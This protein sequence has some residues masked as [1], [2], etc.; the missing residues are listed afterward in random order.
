[1]KWSVCLTAAMLLVAPLPSFAQQRFALIVS[2]AAGGPEY[3]TQY[4]KWSAALSKTLTESL[5]FD[6]ALVTVLSDT[7]RTL[8]P[9]PLRTCGGSLDR[10]PRA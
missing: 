10:L 4:G 2:G 7:T 5:K 9:R 6:P 1:M 3:V 8:M